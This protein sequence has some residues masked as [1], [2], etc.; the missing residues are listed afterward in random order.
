LKKASKQP[1]PATP[2]LPPPPPVLPTPTPTPILLPPLPQFKIEVEF[3]PPK[4]PSGSLPFQT[5]PLKFVPIETEKKEAKRTSLVPFVGGSLH[6]IENELKGLV[7]LLES[8]FIQENEYEL[9]KEN[10]IQSLPA[11]S[12]IRQIY[13]VAA[14]SKVE[15]P[16][17]SFVIFR[18]QQIPIQ[19]LGTQL[20]NS[21]KSQQSFEQSQRKFN[22]EVKLFVSSTF[23]DMQEERDA[24]MKIAFPQLRDFCAER[25]VFF[26]EVDLRWG[27]TAEQAE[28]GKVID[29]C[30]GEID[31][32]RPYFLNVLGERYGWIPTSFSQEQ[33]D[34]F[35]W[36]KAI[37]VGQKSITELEGKRET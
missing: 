10:L 9:R 4:L 24:L 19:Q 36:L 3:S 18:G 21:S 8:G 14:S 29:I 25:G 31:Q 28:T 33:L 35:P 15:N 12:P 22:R 7:L 37:P 27:I 17:T 6:E 1:T 5:E 26:S 16:N 11:N 2:S 20:D 13:E 30:L 23:R 32:C 34:K